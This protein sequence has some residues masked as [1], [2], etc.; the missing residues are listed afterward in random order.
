MGVQTQGPRAD[1]DTPPAPA[2][3]PGGI[4][5]V[6]LWLAGPAIL[7]GIIGWAILGPLFGAAAAVLIGAATGVRVR[8]AGRRALRRIG[9]SLLPDGAEPRARNLVEGLGERTGIEVVSL[10]HI[11][12]DR[13]NAFVTRVGGPAIAFTRGLLNGYSRT[14][15]EAVV[16][17]CLVRLSATSGLRVTT[18]L[19]MALSG[20]RRP[21]DFV[22]A[23]VGHSEDVRAA[24]LT[25]YPPGLAR[26]IEKAAPIE[27]GPGSSWFV[28]GDPSHPSV[29]ERLEQLSDL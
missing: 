20:A 9:G 8:A 14:E 7:A 15:L 27:L 10:W 24:A 18:A 17:H 26:A 12:E 23:P 16:A 3:A 6:G 29:K 4:V 21:A 5:L 25:R 2:P 11:P 13:P 28:S 19:D 22:A 1:W